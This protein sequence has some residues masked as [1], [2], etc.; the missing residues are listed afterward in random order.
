MSI[1]FP[2]E[3]MKK[4]SEL[5]LSRD[6]F[7]SQYYSTNYRECYM[8]SANE[9]LSLP[10]WPIVVLRSNWKSQWFRHENYSYLAL[11][12]P[13]DGDLKIE[14]RDHEIL[15]K[16]GDVG[17]IHPGEDSLL[18]C[19]PSSSCLKL[20]IVFTGALLP[21]LLATTRLTTQTRIHPSDFDTVLALVGEIEQ[22]LKSQD[23]RNI[24]EI[25]GK[26][27]H[28]L[29]LLAAE[30]PTPA[31]DLFERAQDLLRNNIMHPYP[32]AEIARVLGID[33]STLYR[34]F[35]RHL[36]ISPGEYVRRFRI[37]KAKHLLKS[38]RYPIH[39][40]ASETG[41]RTAA[42]FC[43]EFRRRTRTTPLAYRKNPDA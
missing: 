6:H 21:H 25:V 40:V 33:S 16:R 42:A 31:D 32:I 1:P 34:M 27:M 8:L 20:S 43:A 23:H 29:M 35:M 7:E 10:V 3:I 9:A 12:I 22:L 39:L 28:L 24:P 26:A 11:E 41:F 30:D 36:Q 4:T 2:G 15:L 37:Q 17:L 14:Q 38:T 19:G 5:Y 18:K 13:L